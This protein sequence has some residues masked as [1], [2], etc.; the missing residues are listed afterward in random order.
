M[1]KVLAPKAA[2]IV[3]LRSELLEVSVHCLILAC[4]HPFSLSLKHGD[5]H[6]KKCWEH[7][8][9]SY[10]FSSPN[11]SYLLTDYQFSGLLKNQYFRPQ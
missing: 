1:Y 6:S 11:L 4:A 9:I 2:C 5:D 8:L 3:A 10:F 7:N